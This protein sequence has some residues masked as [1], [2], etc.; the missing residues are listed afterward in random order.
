MPPEPLS[1]P[2]LLVGVDGVVS[3]F[4]LD[5]AVPPGVVAVSV[6]GKPHMLSRRVAGRL[7][8]LAATYDVLWCTSW[9]E[10]KVE[11]LPRAL[12]AHLDFPHLRFGAGASPLSRPL[13]LQVVGAYAGPD[14][15]L[16][17]IAGDHDAACAAW[18]R[19][20]PGPTLLV[21]TDPS[22]GLTEAD[23]ERLE[24]W[25]GPVTP[26]ARAARPRGGGGSGPAARSSRRPS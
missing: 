25:A 1:R 13:K 22:V 5:A 15:R 12:G 7:E 11:H 23:T 16:A 24:R 2:L 6:E 20:R 3:L 17:W 4:G 26:A 8:R 14:R 19:D 21:T 9:E 10:R 18:A